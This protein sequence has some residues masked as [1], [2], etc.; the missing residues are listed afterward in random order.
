MSSIPPEIEAEMTPAVR[1]YVEGLLRH[2]AALESHVAALEGQLAAVRAE[3]AASEA[4]AARLQGKVEALQGRVAALEGGKST[5]QNSS[6]PPGTVH[7]HGKPAPKPKKKGRRR[8][9]QPGHA[10][11]SRPLLDADLCDDVIPLFPDHCRRCGET[12]HEEHVEPLRHQVWELPEIKPIV[13]EYQQHR[14]T[15]SC[16]GTTTTAPLPDGVPIGQSGPRLIAFTGLLVG[17]FRQSK[18]RAAFFLQDLLGLPCSASLTVKMQAIVADALASTYDA[19]KASLADAPF[20]HMDET[21]TKEG[22]AKAW[23][24]TVV[25]PECVVFAVFPSRKNHAIP[26]LL[27]DDYQGVVH[28]DRAKMYWIVPRLQWCW[29]HLKRDIQALIDHPDR[30]VKRLGH[31]LMREVRRLFELWHRYKAGKI[32]WTTF[33]RNVRPIRHKIDALFLRGVFSA[34]ARLTGMCR[35]LYDHRA[36]LWT[37]T[38]VEGV[39]P[40]NNAAER[41]LRPAVIARKLSFATQSEQGSRFLERILTI[42]ETCRLHGRGIY[43]WLAAAVKAWLERQPA[44]KLLPAM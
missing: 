6:V 41:S 1:A 26:K 30:V 34:H 29:A 27:G 15:C 9:G 8:G 25:S 39:E 38:R 10:K 5:P 12:L 36:W 4:R 19:L 40:T 17:H 33:R 32:G 16:C 44:P 2:I 3:A 18:R 28:C 42:C 43:Q 31:D 37:F 21:P 24:W 22:D 14:L 11:R 13:T 35:E 7:P 20:V 23:L